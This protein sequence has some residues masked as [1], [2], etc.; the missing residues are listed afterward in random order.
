MSDR[1]TLGLILVLTVGG[2]LSFFLSIARLKQWVDEI[3]TGVV[4]GVP[5]S[6]RHRSMMLWT[7]YMPLNFFVGV[8]LLLLAI[9]YVLLAQ[10]IADPSARFLGYLIAGFSGL[11][12]LGMMSLGTMQLIYL[13]SVLRNTER[14]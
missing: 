5:V 3:A 6:L 11:S 8:Y 4:N 9:G 2:Q 13:L 14:G 1:T 10:S 7:T 12:F